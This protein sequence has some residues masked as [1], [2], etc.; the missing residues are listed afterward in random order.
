MRSRRIPEPRVAITKNADEPK[1]VAEALDLLGI[2]AALNMRDAVVITAN[3]V[4]AKQP[5]TADVVGNVTLKGIIEYIKQ[6]E[7][8]RIVVAAGSGGGDTRDVMK[9]VGYDKII[10]ETGACFVDLNEG[11]FTEIGLNHAKPSSTKL[12]RLIDEMTFHISFT[13]LKIHEEATMSA[14][15]KNMALS[16]PPTAQHGA[17]KK[18]TGIHES[19]QA[20]IAEMARHIPIDLSIVSASPAMI[21]TGPH[22]GIAVH[23]DIVVCGTDPVAADTVGARLLGFKPQAVQYLYA[24]GND[25]IGVSDTAEMSILGMPLK[26]AEESFC[27]SAYKTNGFIV[28]K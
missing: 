24:L 15:V 2:K 12:N 17:P 6:A 11:P 27:Q 1:A 26:D 22:N 9:T 19:L 14:S 21:H 18:D 13:Q 10:R 3:W 5:E 28:D 23:S 25:G 4:S 7:P 20:F 16:W 8:K